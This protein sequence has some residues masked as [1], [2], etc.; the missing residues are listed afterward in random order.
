MKNGDRKKLEQ[1]LTEVR[2]QSALLGAARARR[3]PRVM[4]QGIEEKA[5]KRTFWEKLKAKWV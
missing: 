3:A 2:R 5:L 1:E 4:A